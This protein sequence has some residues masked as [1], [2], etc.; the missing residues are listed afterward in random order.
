MVSY[1][2]TVE[3]NYESSIIEETIFEGHLE[4]LTWS[5]KAAGLLQV[6]FC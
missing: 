3:M 2:W 5:P 6:I 1:T 4:A